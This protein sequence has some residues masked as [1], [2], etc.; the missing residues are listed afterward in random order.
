M[1]LKVSIIV[2][3]YTKGKMQLTSYSIIAFDL[4]LPTNIYQIIYF[5]CNCKKCRPVDHNCHIH[6]FRAIFV[7]RNKIIDILILIPFMFLI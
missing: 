4:I 6:Q 2:N 5:A 1:A 7:L 3:I